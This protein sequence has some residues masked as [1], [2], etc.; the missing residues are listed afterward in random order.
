LSLEK[1]PRRILRTARDPS[2]FPTGEAAAMARALAALA[3]LAALAAVP[4]VAE[5]V[6][7]GESDG[8]PARIGGRRTLVLLGDAAFEASHSRFLASLRG[9]SRGR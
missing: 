8:A 3:V 2:A 7:A 6:P 9:A 4:R 1:R 5:A